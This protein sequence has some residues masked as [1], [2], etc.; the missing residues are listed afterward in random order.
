MLLANKNA[1][2]N[3]A[4]LWVASA[5]L[6]MNV[7]NLSENLFNVGYDIE[8]GDANFLELARTETINSDNDPSLSSPPPFVYRTSRRPPHIGGS[9]SPGIINSL[10]PSMP[11]SSLR[12]SSSVSHRPSVSF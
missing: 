11:V 10:H 5:A 7:D 8:D 6:P 9:L 1:V 4:D 12:H 2:T 3:I